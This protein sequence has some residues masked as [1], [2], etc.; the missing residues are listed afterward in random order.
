MAEATAAA[1]TAAT[2][3]AVKPACRPPQ[4]NDRGSS[5]EGHKTTEAAVVAASPAKKKTCAR[6]TQTT[7]K[8][9]SR[10]QLVIRSVEMARV[11]PKNH[12]K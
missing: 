4:D 1:S 11:H 12:H 10:V 3:A 2:G 7:R 5:R 6:D 9:K 8:I